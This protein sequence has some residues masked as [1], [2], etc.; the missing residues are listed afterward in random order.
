MTPHRPRLHI[1]L[2]ASAVLCSGSLLLASD[3]AN[4]PR[5]R[6]PQD[7]GSTPAGNLPKKIDA[8]QVHWQAPLPGKGFSKFAD[9]VIASIV[10]AG[11]RLFIRGE[12]NLYCVAAR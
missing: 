4:W 1:A 9:K 5:W 6:G 10:P 8:A 2:V 7:N 11:D 12:A 3:A